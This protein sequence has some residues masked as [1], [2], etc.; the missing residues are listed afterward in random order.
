MKKRSIENS[1][2]VLSQIMLPDQ[3]NFRGTVHGGEIMK[4]MDHAAYVAAKRHCQR[5]VGVVTAR[6][7]ELEFHL[8]IQI[9]DI[10]TLTGE[11]VYVGRSSMEVDVKVFIDDIDN[12]NFNRKDKL[13]LTAFFTMV[14]LDENNRPVEIPQLDLQTDEERERFELGKQRYLFY[15]EKR[16][17]NK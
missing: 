15:K 3:A 4:L 7:D 9:E 11:L 14:A 6:V 12:N 5:G 8:P 17:A 10:V 2:V 16:K 13:A 1:R